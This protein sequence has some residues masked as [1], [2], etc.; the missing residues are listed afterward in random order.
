MNCWIKKIEDVLEFKHRKSKRV[1]ETVPMI[2]KTILTLEKSS[3]GLKIKTSF[4]NV[5]KNHRMRA[6]FATDTNTDIHYA[7]SILKLQREI[8]IFRKPGKIQVTA[9]INKYL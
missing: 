8:I 2:I 6:L 4:N 5:A 7:D 3:K 1:E 9:S